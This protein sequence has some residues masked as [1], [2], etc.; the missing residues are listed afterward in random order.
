MEENL[1]LYLAVY[2][3]LLYA[4]VFLIGTVCLAGIAGVHLLRKLRRN[5]SN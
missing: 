4:G 5:K 2:F 1:V 3:F